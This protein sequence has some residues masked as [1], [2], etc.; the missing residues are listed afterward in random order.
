M[1]EYL[2][3]LEGY[4]TQSDFDNSMNL[5]IYLLQSVTF[6]ASIFYVA[7]FKGTFSGAPHQ[8]KRIP[9]LFISGKS[10]PFDR[11]EATL[12]VT[13]SVRPS[14]DSFSEE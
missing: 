2:T 11:D 12:H 4:R 1:A 6:Y 7:F 3:E 10:P 9:V 5:K 14:V 8:Y 13:L